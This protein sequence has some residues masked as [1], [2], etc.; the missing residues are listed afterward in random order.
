MRII[1]Y[2]LR[3][4]TISGFCFVVLLP[5]E[6]E[7]QRDAV[8]DLST[9]TGR[10]FVR[11]HNICHFWSVWH[12]QKW[13]NPNVEIQ[14]SK[15]SFWVFDFSWFSWFMIWWSHFWVISIST[16]LKEFIR[17]RSGQFFW[18]Q[19]HPSSP[20]LKKTRTNNLQIWLSFHLSKIWGPFCP[21]ETSANS[22][23]QWR[24][25]VNLQWFSWMS[26][27]QAEAP[28]AKI[29]KENRRKEQRLKWNVCKY[30]PNAA[31]FR[32]VYRDC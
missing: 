3:L 9:S 7:N 6:R 26:L 5:G 20:F 16:F 8:G 4:I 12:V 31:C 11:R 14:F 23:W 29:G 28:W 25:S 15:S 32:S 21:Q 24:W 30:P 19:Q 2:S 13:L 18:S 1:P 10:K 17:E 27:A 22:L